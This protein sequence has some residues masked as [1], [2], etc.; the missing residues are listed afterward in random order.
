MAHLI[1]YDGADFQGRRKDVYGDEAFLADFNDITSSFVI[2]EGVWEFFAD[3]NFRSPMG[4]SDP[5]R[6]VPGTYRWV[7]SVGIRND[8]I[9][10]VKLVPG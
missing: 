4:W 5:P 3:A 6:F 2:R 1:L 8:T 7:E 10:S 9:S